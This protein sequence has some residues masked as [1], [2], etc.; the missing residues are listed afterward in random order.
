MTMI[1]TTT[2]TATATTALSRPGA[3]EKR[4]LLRLALLTGLLVALLSGVRLDA[5]EASEAAS[6]P[7]PRPATRVVSS[8]TAKDLRPPSQT[9]VWRRAGRGLW[10]L[11]TLTLSGR[12]AQVDGVLR[13]T[14]AE[15]VA[16]P[17]TLELLRDGAIVAAARC[18]VELRPRG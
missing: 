5:E 13:N 6:E 14:H 7:A 17:L 1:R 9:A 2:A 3:P 18:H 8:P 15:A 4:L 10:S 16:G 11:P 12:R